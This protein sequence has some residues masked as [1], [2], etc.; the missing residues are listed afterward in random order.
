MEVCV[1]FFLLEFTLD[2]QCVV[3][4][5]KKIQKPYSHSLLPVDN[6]YRRA[7]EAPDYYDD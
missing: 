7:Y 1:V 6:I 3:I 4:F 5:L 2:Y